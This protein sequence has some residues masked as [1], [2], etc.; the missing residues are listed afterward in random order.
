MSITKILNTQRNRAWFIKSKSLILN[1]LRPLEK[2]LKLPALIRSRLSSYQLRRRLFYLYQTFNKCQLISTS[3]RDRPRKMVMWAHLPYPRTK[4]LN[5][6]LSSIKQ[7]YLISAI[8][9]YYRCVAIGSCRVSVALGRVVPSHM[10]ILSCR[11]RNMS[12]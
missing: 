10:A 5:L 6:L 7:R 12:P 9:P 8:S 4:L 1:Y 2:L 11:R 3:T